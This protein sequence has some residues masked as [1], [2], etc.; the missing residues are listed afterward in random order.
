[1]TPIGVLSSPPVALA[2]LTSFLTL[3]SLEPPL[4]LP[5]RFLFCT[6]LPFPAP[7]LPISAVGIIPTILHDDRRTTKQ[8]A[9]RKFWPTLM[10]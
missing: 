4:F 7:V 3:I 10:S 6:A 1:M 8:N 9:K 2:I 5:T